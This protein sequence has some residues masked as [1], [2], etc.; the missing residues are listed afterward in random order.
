[1]YL[2]TL[3]IALSLLSSVYALPPTKGELSAATPDIFRRNC[4]TSGGKLMLYLLAYL[5]IDKKN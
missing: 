2:S 4:G 1:M 3:T 5:T